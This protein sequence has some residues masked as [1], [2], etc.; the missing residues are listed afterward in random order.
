MFTSPLVGCDSLLPSFAV[1]SESPRDGAAGSSARPFKNSATSRVISSV[2]GCVG[3]GV[4]GSVGTIV[5]TCAALSNRTVEL[6]L[7]LGDPSCS[8]TVM[9]GVGDSE[10]VADVDGSLICD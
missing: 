8:A 10:V 2:V 6:L 4:V 1:I 9:H 7:C 5:G 3:V